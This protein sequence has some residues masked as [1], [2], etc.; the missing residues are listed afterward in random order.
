MSHDSEPQGHLTH[1][2]T[3]GHEPSEVGIRRML[4]FIAALATLC[5]SSMVVVAL[6]MSGFKAEETADGT[7]TKQLIETKEGDFPAPRLQHDDAFD[8]EKFREQETAALKSYG[9]ADRKAGVAQIPIDRAMTILIKRGLPKVKAPETKPQANP[10]KP[11]TKPA[12][13]EPGK[14][15]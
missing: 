10:E 11:E 9:W 4:I 14:K 2:T 15:E 3:T 7:T 13:T 5:A 12:S 6:V 8:M 1:G